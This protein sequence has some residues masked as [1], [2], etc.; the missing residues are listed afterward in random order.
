MTK[1]GGSGTI[2][3]LHMMP[4]SDSGWQATFRAATNQLPDNATPREDSASTW[5]TPIVAWLWVEHGDEEHGHPMVV[6]SGEILDAT[7][8]ENYA[9]VIR[10]A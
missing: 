1:C 2:E 10:L 5:S 7:T 4:C 9:G 8:V 6:L 3:V